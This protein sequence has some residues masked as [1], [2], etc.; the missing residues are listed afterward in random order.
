MQPSTLGFDY[1]IGTEYFVYFGPRY[2]RRRAAGTCCT[3]V[4]V[5]V[6]CVMLYDFGLDSYIC[7][8]VCSQRVLVNLPL[9]YV[10]DR[11]AK[12]TINSAYPAAPFSRTIFDHTTL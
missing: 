2:G 5:G 3:G 8:S 1:L 12:I 11:A 10:P 4:C 9:Q 7:G 6:I